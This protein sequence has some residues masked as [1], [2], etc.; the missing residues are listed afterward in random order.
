MKRKHEDNRPVWGTVGLII[1]GIADIF[2]GLILIS[3][4]LRS[5]INIDGIDTLANYF[6]FCQVS[7]YIAVG[8]FMI[9]A[10]LPKLHNPSGRQIDQ[11][12]QWVY[13]GSHKKFKDASVR[14]A[15][16]HKHGVGTWDGK[17]KGDQNFLMVLFIIIAAVLIFFGVRAV[18]LSD[19]Y[20]ILDQAGAL[21]HSTALF[22]VSWV[23]GAGVGGLS[24][25][26]LKYAFWDLKLGIDS[27]G[28]QTTGRAMNSKYDFPPLVLLI[29]RLLLSLF[30]LFMSIY[31]VILFIFPK[32]SQAK[33]GNAFP[34]LLPYLF[35]CAGA[36]WLLG[37]LLSKLTYSENYKDQMQQKQELSNTKDTIEHAFN[38]LFKADTNKQTRIACALY[39]IQERDKLTSEGIDLLVKALKGMTYE[40]HG[41]D[42][43]SWA[44]LLKRLFSQI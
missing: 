42:F 29:P 24:I 18:Y 30:V 34:I 23:A 12:H 22:W 41:H 27:M 2:I 17:V 1:F 28:V 16:E 21:I 36:L 19:R 26:M 11:T 31:G 15:Y 35:M 39:L 8:I 10:L 37:I 6:F 4:S 20:P 5:A 7:G 38:E 44:D 43:Q 3:D 14:D 9:A 33:F 32:L 40:D 13:A 25:L